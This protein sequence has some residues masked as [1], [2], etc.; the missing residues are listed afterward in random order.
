MLIRGGTVASLIAGE[1][2]GT[3]D[4]G[5]LVVRSM[6]MDAGGPGSMVV[7]EDEA[8]QGEDPPAWLKAAVDGLGNM[9]G[10]N[11]LQRMFEQPMAPAPQTPTKETRTSLDFRTD[12]SDE[13]IPAV[14]STSFMTPSEALHRRSLTRSLSASQGAQAPSAPIE[15]FDFAVPRPHTAWKSQPHFVPSAPEF[16][17][18]QDP[19]PDTEHSGDDERVT[20][21]RHS[22]A[23]E[24]TPRPRQGRYLRSSQTA[25]IPQPSLDEEDTSHSTAEEHTASTAPSIQFAHETPAPRFQQTDAPEAEAAEQ[26]P[27]FS[28]SGSSRP[29]GG[30]SGSQS[31]S[32][33]FSFPYDTFTRNHLSRLVEEIDDL[34]AHSSSIPGPTAGPSN[35]SV[36]AN[37]APELSV[38]PGHS[39]PPPVGATS[40]ESSADHWHAGRTPFRA[41][42]LRQ[43]QEEKEWAESFLE[44][45]EYAKLSTSGGGNEDEGDD[46]DIEGVSSSE[47]PLGMGRIRSSKRVRLSPPRSRIFGGSG[48]SNR[49]GRSAALGRRQQD[50]LVVAAN[51]ASPFRR[52]PTAYTE[53]PRTVPSS[54][55]S[56]RLR[57][58][59]ATPGPTPSAR[60]GSAR[61]DAA[62]PETKAEGP[63]RDLLA[64]AQALMA[65]I[66]AKGSRDPVTAPVAPLNDGVEESSSAA[67][68]VTRL[69]R[70]RAP[71]P[72][73]SWGRRTGHDLGESQ[74][75]QSSSD[76]TQKCGTLPPLTPLLDQELETTEDDEHTESAE[77]ERAAQ[78]FRIKTPGKAESPRKLL[79]KLTAADE[80]DAEETQVG[81]VETEEPPVWEIRLDEDGPAASVLER[82]DYGFPAHEHVE[83]QGQDWDSHTR[84]SAATAS[85]RHNFRNQDHVGLESLASARSPAAHAPDSR[86]HFAT[87]PL[88]PTRPSLPL[89]LSVPAPSSRAPSTNTA[90][91]NATSAA[92][93]H[94]RHSLATTGSL[95]GSRL[96]LMT[97]GPEDVE[98]LLSQRRLGK[99]IFDASSGRWL[100]AGRSSINHTAPMSLENIPPAPIQEESVWQDNEDEGSSGEEE[101]PFRDFESLTSRRARSG[102]DGD[103]DDDGSA[104][105]GD[106][107][108]FI[109][110]DDAEEYAVRIPEAEGDQ[111]RYPDVEVP[112]SPPPK[113][114]QESP[115]RPRSALKGK[116]HNSHTPAYFLDQQSKAN[117]SVSFSDDRAQGRVLGAVPSQDA[118]GTRLLDTSDDESEARPNASAE[119]SARTQRIAAALDELQD[120][121]AVSLVEP[122]PSL[123]LLG[124]GGR[125]FR[126]KASA[127]RRSTSSD[128]SAPPDGVDEGARANNANATFLTECSFGISHDH[129][130]KLITDVEPF[131]PSW[132]QLKIIDLSEKGVES[133]VR[134][135]EFLP[136]LDEANL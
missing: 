39:T 30:Q 65:R 124:G 129:L 117:R 55:R 18:A 132:E 32:K 97:I 23:F 87:Q 36:A 90:I 109:P 127:L 108:E 8:K 13:V 75:R 88:L 98:D 135:K 26:T 33:V 10:P 69:E 99:M 104:S 118:R 52:P 2:D 76:G 62:M 106:E 85:I 51:R 38:G 120:H 14:P 128:N 74:D 27:Y 95:G 3:G 47:R 46:G 28:P 41:S 6:L 112:H 70:P 9:F 54:V 73:S 48:A 81:L 44:P 79:R 103:L 126:P 4:A 92:M 20:P 123:S 134:L 93:A 1:V 125:R 64:E 77:W 12:R 58:A 56:R 89:A 83:G 78:S 34:S 96:G 40:H 21:E 11:R 84:V 72:R 16:E 19:G 130:V 100:R 114:V 101:D 71:T 60:R 31:H 102:A 113:P 17:E 35:A 91:S 50:S 80:V 116:S 24:P 131:E 136:R 7:K 25:G 59:A 86:R 115:A 66:K 110:H 107:H 29:F 49:S 82:T 105:S 42:L 15:P 63:K 37:L 53:T 121:G 22:K 68:S 122:S 43:K 61:S 119:P 94:A 45:S 111:S 5:S 67:E 133:L 57:S